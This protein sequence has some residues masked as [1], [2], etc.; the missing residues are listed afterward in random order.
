MKTTT[1]KVADQS[2]VWGKDKDLCLPEKYCKGKML[3]AE[4]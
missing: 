3:V 2:K 1:L 4:D